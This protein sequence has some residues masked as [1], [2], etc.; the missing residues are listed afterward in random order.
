[1]FTYH[2]ILAFIFTI[3]IHCIATL[4]YSV[5]L[6]GVITGR[7]AASFALFNILVLVS[8]TSMAFQAP[9]L[10]RKIEADI[11]ASQIQHV[12]TMFHLLI[13]AASIGTLIGALLIPTFRRL[14][15]RFVERFN[16]ERSIPRILMHGFSKAGVNYI[17]S[18]M[19][20]PSSAAFEKIRDIKNLP[21]RMILL[22]CLVVSLFTV[23][24]FSSLYANYFRPDLRVTCTAL[25][26]LITG[27]AAIVLAVYIDPTISLLT[28]DV[29]EGKESLSYFY[30]C[31]IAIVISRFIG[32]LLAQ[33]LLIPGAKLI[34]WI[35][36]LL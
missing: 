6:V 28:D 10:A 18:N 3:I 11:A 30:T 35:A 27:I 14:F 5:R 15:A 25:S 12:G 20:A 9:L 34:A 19:T 4:A 24:V 21:K 7:L 13:L 2:I 23:G 16:I 33:L 17:R 36:G 8:R 22:N 26:I 1:M 31:I 32:T 29:M